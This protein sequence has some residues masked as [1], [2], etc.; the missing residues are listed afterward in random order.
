MATLREIRRRVNSVKKI[1]EITAAMK[2]VSA[3][4][5][6]NA[7]AAL[8]KMRPYAS[9][10]A[11]IIARL[12]YCEGPQGHPLLA[13]RGDRKALLVVVTS[14]RGLCGPFNANIIRQAV[15]YQEEHRSKY[16]AY[17]DMVCVGKKGYDYFRKRGYHI[18]EQHIGFFKGI[19]YDSARAIGQTA[20]KWFLDLDVDRVDF[21]YHHF[22]SAGRQTVATRAVLPMRLCDIAPAEEYAPGARDS[23]GPV[24][25]ASEGPGVTEYIYEP[26]REVILDE[27]L[28][29]YVN[30]QVWRILQESV[31]SEHGA[32]MLA[33]EAATDNCDDM[34]RDLQL[35]YNKAR[36]AAITKEL[37]EIVA[38]AEALK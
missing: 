20:M 30:V 22:F 28:P 32:R 33:M 25:T 16:G 8:I 11:E 4:E 1:R 38:A 9:S 17:A 34:L 18:L 3:I 35:L 5:V 36:Q 15:R 21:L 24:P 2:T 10:L 31:S 27:V 12:S 13:D 37:M 19:K 29:L 14:D 6:R 26:G 7:E 23:G